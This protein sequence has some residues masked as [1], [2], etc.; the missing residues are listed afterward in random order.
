MFNIFKKKDPNQIAA[1]GYTSNYASN[2]ANYSVFSTPKTNT[3]YRTVQNTGGGG[4]WGPTQNLFSSPTPKSPTVQAS[5]YG[6][7][8]ASN[9]A[10]YQAPKPIQQPQTTQQ[11][12]QLN[13]MD[14]F[15]KGQQNVAE[16]KKQ[17]A[18]GQYDASSKRN[19]DLYNLSQDQLRGMK[20]S[21][22]EAFN[23]FEQGTL[24]GLERVRSAGERNKG[25][26]EEYY[27]DA[28][29]TA[30][31]AR[32]ETQGDAQRRF[33]ALNTIDSFGE[34]SFKQANE[35]IDSDFNRVTQSLAR[36][37]A[38]K[39]AEIDDEIFAAEDTANQAI[40]AERVNLQQVL[41]QIDSSLQQGTIEYQFAEQQALGQYQENVSAIEEWF[42]G[43]QYQTESQ[44]LALQTELA[45]MN[46]FTPE[47][48]ATGVPTNQQEYEFLISNQEA[49]KNLYPEL[50]GDTSAGEG[51]NK[52]LT[53]VNNLISGNV[54]AIS[55]GFRPGSTPVLNKIFGGG[56]EAAQW[57]GL[58]NLLTLARRGE[59][60]G[61]GAVSDFETKM[62]EKAAL[63]GLDPT[64]QSEAQFLAGLKQLQQ[65]LMQG[66]A[67]D[68]NNQSVNLSQFVGR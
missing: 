40:Q 15:L 43:I 29:R 18:Q 58:K 23:Q 36:E 61:T 2:P 27:G 64:K 28:Q 68:V 48:M 33:S 47:F 63:A 52:A 60:K 20:G 51:K 34:G 67:V 50:F 39:L 32:R 13:L 19:T 12:P 14:N 54:D 44:K 42:N 16:Q 56:Q 10:N 5:G 3:A 21:A 66:G 57:E 8:Y 30:A 22:Q 38:N 31:Q 62:L 53:M 1:S 11:S 17:L 55:G 45:K 7:N 37:K 59:L 4:S 65:D 35:N 46:S 6:S 9:P 25:N 41:R 49:F 24:G 26:V